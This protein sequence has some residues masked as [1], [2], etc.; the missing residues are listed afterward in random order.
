MQSVGLEG[1]VDC[2]R[3]TPS[4]ASGRWVALVT[5]ASSGS[6]KESPMEIAT[7]GP[8]AFANSAKVGPSQSH[9][10]PFCLGPRA[11]AIAAHVKSLKSPQTQRHPKANIQF[12]L[13]AE[14]SRQ[15]TRKTI[16]R[17]SVRSWLLFSSV[18]PRCLSIYLALARTSKFQQPTS[19]LQMPPT[20]RPDDAC[21]IAH[22]PLAGRDG[23]SSQQI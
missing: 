13:G 17:L 18:V 3:L 10:R 9:R 15:T 19:N 23:R 16:A 11:G 7:I 1:R 14:R 12:G 20:I 2:V 21:S 5:E 6:R 8:G 4:G 22:S